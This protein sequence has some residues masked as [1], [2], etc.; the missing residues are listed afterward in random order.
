MSEL[1]SIAFPG[2]DDAERVRSKLL[3]LQKAHLIDLEDAAVVV[4]DEKGRVRLRQ[5]HNLPASGAATGGLWGLLLGALFAMPLL[6]VAIGAASGAL[7]GALADIGVDD[8]FMRAMGRSLEK[9][10]SALFILV[11]NVT[12]DK[13]LAELEPMGGH[14]L[15][16]S[17]SVEDEAKLRAVLERGGAKEHVLPAA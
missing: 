12:P 4:K 16:T 15:R 14:I 8:D 10:T 17:L 3:D 5:L 1:I 11:R 6:G 7:G 2:P 13:V 9:N